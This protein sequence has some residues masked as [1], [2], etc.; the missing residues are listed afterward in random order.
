MPRMA[1][2]RHG[3]DGSG[4]CLSVS[5]VEISTP[6]VLDVEIVNAHRHLDDVTLSPFETQLLDSDQETREAFQTFL[7]QNR[8]SSFARIVARR[9]S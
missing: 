3:R 6:G 9:A 5:I 2:S 7:Q 4:R 1:R 8:M